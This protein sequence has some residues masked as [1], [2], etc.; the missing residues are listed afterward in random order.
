MK[1]CQQIASLLVAIENCEKSGNAD[2]LDKHTAELARI[3]SERMPSGSGFD[4]GTK[5][6]DDS[7]PDRLKFSTEFHHMDESGYC[8][9]TN[10]VVTARP[11]FVYGLTISGPNRNEIKDYIADAFETALNGDL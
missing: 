10:H 7:G 8:G 11:S 2:W 5:L 6:C 4:C 3:V 1:V 9:W